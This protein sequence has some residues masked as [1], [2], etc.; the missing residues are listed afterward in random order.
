MKRKDF[1]ILFCLLLLVPTLHNSNTTTSFQNIGDVNSITIPLNSIEDFEIYDNNQFSIYAISG[2]GSELDPW[3]IRDKDVYDPTAD[4]GIYIHDTTNYFQL[5]NCTVNANRYDVCIE[6]VAPGTATVKNCS[7]ELAATGLGIINSADAY[8]R[9]CLAYDCVSAGF[10]ADNASDILYM[11]NYAYDCDRGFEIK[12]SYSADM[13]WCEAYDSDYDDCFHVEDS[14]DVAVQNCIANGAVAN[15]IYF[16]NCTDGYA[17]L[18]SCSDNVEHGISIWDS[19]NTFVELNTFVNC[20]LGVYD[21]D[22]EDLLSL[23]V[24]WDNTVNGETLFYGENLVDFTF[25][26]T[27]RPEIILV[28]CT[29]IMI[30]GHNDFAQHT[31]VNIL[32]HFSK[33]V[34]I[35]NCDF[36]DTGVALAFFNSEDFKIIGCSFTG[37]EMIGGMS[38]FSSSKGLI[39]YNTFHDILYA[40]I[41][42][43]DYS[44][45][46]TI[47]ENN[48]ENM[49]LYAISLDFETEDNYIYHNNFI[50]CSSFYSSYGVDQGTDNFWYNETLQEGNYWDSWVSGP[51]DIYGSAGSQDL[52]PLGGIYV[53]PE[54][55][56][57]T[58]MISIVSLLTLLSL[59]VIG[60]RRK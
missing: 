39:Q 58:T 30:N 11:Y 49:Y 7:F 46:I 22:V 60:L 23:D 29:N 45:N 42:V 26:A 12:S 53:I 37:D 34:T 21:D 51:Y 25:S 10:E 35:Q 13:F 19:P 57:S 15:G 54:Y 8:V 4:I 55:S 14:W 28:N 52:Y 43:N 2:N 18:N 36:I 48:L 31:T 1:L 56:I 33:S 9:D 3:I 24:Q 44:S 40:G 41:A 32:V 16:E 59:V 50:N 20:D 5:I 17:G 6:D 27:P 38:T 47:I